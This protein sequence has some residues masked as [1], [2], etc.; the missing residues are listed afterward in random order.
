MDEEARQLLGQA[1]APRLRL[2]PSGL[3]GD[4]HIAQQLRMEMREGPLAHGEG[5]HIGRP[6]DAPVLRIEPMDARIVDDEHAQLTA[7]TVEGGE[8]RPEDLVEHPGVDRD[9]LLSVP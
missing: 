8:E 4:D 6:I 1:A 7:L 3:G 2:T 5:Q 9:A